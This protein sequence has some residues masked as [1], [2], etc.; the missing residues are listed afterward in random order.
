MI[1]FVALSLSY[2]LLSIALLFTY[3]LITKDGSCKSSTSKKKEK[4]SEEES[5]GDGTKNIKL[6]IQTDIAVS[7]AKQM[8]ETA[9]VVPT[10]DGDCT[11]H[12]NLQQDRVQCPAQRLYG[13]A[14]VV[15]KCK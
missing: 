15:S 11:T 9:G 4:K 2:S 14:D 6:K 8:L 7:C 13:S 1:A 12:N 10:T 5:E 3:S